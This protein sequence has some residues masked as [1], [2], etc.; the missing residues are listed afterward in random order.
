MT[1]SKEMVG[2]IIG[3]LNASELKVKKVLQLGSSLDPEKFN[4]DSDFDL[5]VFVA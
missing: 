4:M 3:T 1:P 2:K 5:L